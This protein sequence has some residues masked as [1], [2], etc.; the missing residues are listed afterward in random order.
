MMIRFN[1]G[2][3]KA[4]LLSVLHQEER[5]LRANTDNKFK[6]QIQRDDDYNGNNNIVYLAV[7]KY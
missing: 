7:D 3:L 6:E 1:Q 2:K 4:I 5:H